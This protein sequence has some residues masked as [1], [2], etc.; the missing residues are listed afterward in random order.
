[1]DKYGDG[2]D[3]SPLRKNKYNHCSSKRA[4]ADG[5]AAAAPEGGALVQKAVRWA[6]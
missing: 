1:M 2:V 6:R 5:A 3:L 4:P